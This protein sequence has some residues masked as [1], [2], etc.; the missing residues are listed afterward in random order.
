[1]EHKL[2]ILSRTVIVLWVLKLY[3][4]TNQGITIIHHFQRMDGDFVRNREALKR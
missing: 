2:K 3:L 1:M 4:L